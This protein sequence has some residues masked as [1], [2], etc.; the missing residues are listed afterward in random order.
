M[1]VQ[2]R[3][4]SMTE[5]EKKTELVNTRSAFTRNKHVRPYRNVEEQ[6]SL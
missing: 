6:L 4:K 5:R 1:H 2:Y 3:N